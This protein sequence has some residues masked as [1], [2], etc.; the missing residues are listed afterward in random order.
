MH[1]GSLDD[2]R[3]HL[4]FSVLPGVWKSG[5][6]RDKLGELGQMDDAHGH[7]LLLQQMLSVDEG[8]L[9]SDRASSDAVG[10]KVVANHQNIFRFQP[11]SLQGIQ[12]DFRFGLPVSGLERVD[13]MVSGEELTQAM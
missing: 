10:L 3:K 11:H 5:K 2:F 6:H 8:S 13:T 7:V 12:K 1:C 4:K 9:H